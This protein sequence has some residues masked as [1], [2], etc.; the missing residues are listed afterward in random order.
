MFLLVDTDGASVEGSLGMRV[1]ALALSSLSALFLLQFGASLLHETSADA[2]WVRWLPVGLMGIW[3][4][5]F[6][7]P[8]V[9]GLYTSI[10]ETRLPAT[11]QCIGCH[12]DA[13]ASYVVAGRDWVTS[14]GVWSRYLLFLPGSVV[15]AVGLAAQAPGFR[16]LNMPHI[17]RQ[18]VLA[19]GAFL[20]TA[21]VAGTVV[22]PVPYPPASV[23][24]Y[25]TFTTKTGIP[26]QILW[27]LSATA[28]SFFVVR[29]L[30]VFELERE[31]QL[32]LATA[33]RLQAQEEALQ[34][35][36]HAHRQA[37]RWSQTLEKMVDERTA[38]LE[39]F[40]K[41]TSDVSAL[42]ALDEV[43]STVV[44]R[45]AALSRADVA[46]LLLRDDSD[47]ELTTRAVC[48]ER[49]K[50]LAALHLAWGSEPAEGGVSTLDGLALLG[51]RAAR[52]IAPELADAM[53]ADEVQM[54]LAAPLR[55]RGRSQ[56]V[57]LVGTRGQR[58]LRPEAAQTMSRLASA[59]SLILENAR[60]YVE[61]Q[62]L[63]VFEE[64]DRI[65][66][67]M[68]DSLAQVLGLLRLKTNLAGIL[69][70]QGDLKGAESQINSVEEAA[71]DGYR[72]VR[73]SILELR[74][75]AFARRGL[76]EGLVDYASKF[77]AETGIQAEV[78]VDEGAPGHIPPSTEI[79]LIRIIQEALANV[80]KHAGACRAVVRLE[81]NDG[82][83]LASVRDDGVGFNL[84]E[85]LGEN[86]SHFGLQTMRERAESVGGQLKVDSAPGVGT[87]V[88]VRVS[89]TS[90]GG[91]GY[92]NS[93]GHSS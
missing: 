27:A 68:H 9:R 18:T 92:A 48:G 69:L 17:A 36:S 15:A 72:E 83:L 78:E 32:R 76:I 71:E 65:A 66:R 24:N 49:T 90:R 77:S 39:A 86:G 16:A 64:R 75:G 42:A 28:V 91:A 84:Q 31:R 56:G 79:Q 46:A 4:G 1:L 51:R 54:F 14:A 81:L 21:V 67:E 26:P 6:A 35:R 12:W 73:A 5:S 87:R 40:Y 61:S 57:L 10:S 93:E 34:A 7:I 60:L 44:E 62:R 85:A 45:S 20:V 30:N 88:A 58:R 2:R 47:E 38:E 41:I 50:G 29:I 13:A 63:A 74:S 23:L 70:A 82:H 22:A 53:A 52:R 89:V 55:A 80:R 11:Q 33:E 3:V 19:A 8:Q 25:A 59:T 43:L 37:Q